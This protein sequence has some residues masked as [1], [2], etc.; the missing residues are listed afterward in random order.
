MQGC[1][2]E[3]VHDGRP[4]QI[5][6]SRVAAVLHHTGL[7]GCHINAQRVAQLVSG[8]SRQVAAAVQT[9]LCLSP[10]ARPHCLQALASWAQQAQ[11][12]GWLASGCST[13]TMAGQV[14]CQQH[15]MHVGAAQRLVQTSGRQ[16]CRELAPS[17][18]GC[19]LSGS[20]LHNAQG[21]AMHHKAR[22]QALQAADT[23]KPLGKQRQAA[24]PWR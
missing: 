18:G 22:L 6:C 10:S 15:E 24:A 4:A 9:Q 5:L 21:E 14:W 3:H 19:A 16:L 7:Q 11:P 12:Q 1:S 23:A 13:S 2:K 17:A 8:C 20:S